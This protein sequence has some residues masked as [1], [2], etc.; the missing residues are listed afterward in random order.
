MYNL[1][2]KMKN[3]VKHL[4]DSKKFVLSALKFWTTLYNHKSVLFLIQLVNN[5]DLLNDLHLHQKVHLKYEWGNISQFQQQLTMKCNQT[6]NCK[7]PTTMPKMFQSFK[8]RPRARSL[9]GLPPKP[10]GES[11]PL[12]KPPRTPTSSPKTTERRRR[13]Y[14]I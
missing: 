5:C 7:S 4:L 13:M 9:S 6:G 10:G 14:S 11:K 1:P 2:L 12:R 8:L 3:Q